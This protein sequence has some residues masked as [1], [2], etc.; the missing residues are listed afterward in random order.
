MIVV[1]YACHLRKGEGAGLLAS[2]CVLAGHVSLQMLKGR[3]TELWLQSQGDQD[4][5]ERRGKTDAWT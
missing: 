5:S 4:C 1:P 3:S 2:L